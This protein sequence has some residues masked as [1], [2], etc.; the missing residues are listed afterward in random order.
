MPNQK[1]EHT[2]STHWI[3]LL[4][5]DTTYMCQ[6]PAIKC[7]S[8]LRSNLNKIGSPH[9]LN[10]IPL[11]QDFG[12][13]EKSDLLFLFLAVETPLQTSVFTPVRDIV[14]TE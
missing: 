12:L 11:N 14:L 5:S 9:H 2:L 13:F 7:V 8:A 1:P 6:Y 3:P 10:P 4:I